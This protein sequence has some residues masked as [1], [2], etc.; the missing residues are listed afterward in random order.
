MAHTLLGICGS[1]RAGSINLKLLHEAIRAYGPADAQIA[2][3]RLPL[4]DGDL[5]TTKGIPDAVQTLAGQIA[6]ADAVI[7]ASPEYNKSIP[8]GLKNALDWVSRVKDV[9]PWAGK[10]VAIIS[11]AAGRTG[12]ETGQYAIRHAL[13]PFRPRFSGGPIL[14]VASGSNQFDETGRLIN[15]RSAA[16]LA[17]AMQA[18]R[19]EA[20]G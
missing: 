3:I 16:T 15:E 6:A 8:G 18:L 12:G 7:I 13:T 5:E 11:A 4:Y 17:A 10:P 14:L 19:A 2:D 20:G 1:L 9:K